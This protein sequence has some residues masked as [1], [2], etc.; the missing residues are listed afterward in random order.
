LLAAIAD[1]R[2][3]R[4]TMVDTDWL[5]IAPLSSVKTLIRDAPA[6]AHPPTAGHQG[7]Q[8]AAYWKEDGV[9]TAFSP[10]PQPWR[11]RASCTKQLAARRNEQAA[12]PVF[13]FAGAPE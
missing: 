6:P 11:V 9:T 7:I 12:T 5:V 1:D 13:P 10:S 3:P 2:R 4:T 8:P